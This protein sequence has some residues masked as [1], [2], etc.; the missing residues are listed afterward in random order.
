MRTTLLPLKDFAMLVQLHR[1]NRFTHAL[2]ILLLAASG[3]NRVH[4]Q[5]NP[6]TT[7]VVLLGTGMPRPDPKA[8]GPATAIV[9]GAQVFLVDA[10]PGVMRQLRAAGLPINGVTALFVT[11][12]HTDHT[13]G[14]P[15]LIFTSWV[16]GRKKPL[17]AYGPKGLQRMTD[18][19]MEAYSEDIDVRTDGLE[20]ETAGGYA[21]QVHEIDT[22]IV[23]D[24][25]GVRVRAIAVP[26]GSWGASYAFRFDTPD[27]TIVVSGDTRY[28]ERLM[29]ASRGVDVLVHEVYPEVRLKPE[30]RP[31]GDDWPRYMKEYH[32]S[33]VELGRLAALAQP[34][35]L[36]LTHLV[37]MGGSD[38]ELLEGIR[39][40]GFDGN[41][42]VGKDLDR[43]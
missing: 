10:G 14:Y 8:S 27:R 41:T 11:H 9:M 34:K 1:S 33:D 4:A 18:R 16:M 35:L 30:P 36:V 40:G 39:R 32:T 21:V 5:R 31:G 42:V 28:S 7:F 24:S 2:I 22:G 26:H 19:L 12:L 25:A 37:R 15:D 6:D 23:Y 13:L 17:H 38:S 3:S 20:H 43:W 29:E